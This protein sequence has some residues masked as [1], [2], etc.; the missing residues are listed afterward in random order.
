MTMRKTNGSAARRT[1]PRWLV[2]AI[3]AAVLAVPPGVATANNLWM[4]GSGWV[5]HHTR[6]YYT[7]NGM[8]ENQTMRSLTDDARGEWDADTRLELQRSTHDPSQMHLIDGHYGQTGWSGLAESYVHSTH[9]HVNYNLTYINGW[10]DYNKRAI[11]CQEIGH[12]LG[13]DHAPG[14][15]MGFTYFSDYTSRVGKHSIDTLDGRYAQPH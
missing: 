6:Y 15:C 7:Y 1:V 9:S 3:A 5:H 13:L 10:S 12:V 8:D 14:D 11:G 2:L 4:S